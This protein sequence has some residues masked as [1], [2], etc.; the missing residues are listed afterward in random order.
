MTPV[1]EDEDSFVDAEEEL[2]SEISENEVM[3]EGEEGKEEDNN[4][5]TDGDDAEHEVQAKTDPDLFASAFGNNADSEEDDEVVEVSSIKATPT[6]KTAARNLDFDRSEHTKG[7]KETTRGPATPPDLPQFSGPAPIDPKLDRTKSLKVQERFHKR[8]KQLIPRLP[9]A[10]HRYWIGVLHMDVKAK[11]AS[12]E[13]HFLWMK[14]NKFTTVGTVWH[15][16]QQSAAADGFVLLLGLERVDFKDQAQE[17][18]HFN[19]KKIMF[20]AVSE[21]SPEAKGRQ[22]TEGLI[23]TAE[24]VEVMLEK[25]RNLFKPKAEVEVIEIDD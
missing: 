17:L 10:E 12:Q 8:A 3:V 5:E 25:R 11:S 16:Y 24:E 2:E 18:D 22:V 4:E 14:G 9:L 7:C 15:M 20:R 13:K 21:K 1:D 6:E 23:M 19:D